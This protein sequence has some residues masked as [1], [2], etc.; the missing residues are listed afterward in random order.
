[1]Q[2]S[3]PRRGRGE[4]R[5]TDVAAL[6]APTSYLTIRQRVACTRHEA[7]LPS[8]ELAKF[9]PASTAE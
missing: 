3:A 6:S 5:K 8:A 4:W 2:V 1:V 7:E 9:R